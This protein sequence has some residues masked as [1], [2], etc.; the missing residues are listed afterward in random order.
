MHHQ[1]KPDVPLGH[2]DRNPGAPGAPQD[3]DYTP[4]KKYIAVDHE[5][6][7][8]GSFPKKGETPKRSYT[9][10]NATAGHHVVSAADGNAQREER[11]R[12][13]ES[14]RKK[15]EAIF[16]SHR[17]HTSAKKRVNSANADRLPA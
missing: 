2:P 7:P 13:I 5:Q 4:D 16:D 17:R 8:I 10:S 9:T 6:E 14:E 15:T 11:R 1:R 3:H 12:H